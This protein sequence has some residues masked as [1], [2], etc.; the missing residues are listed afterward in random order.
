M[1]RGRRI[2]LLAHCVLNGNAKVEG[3]CG[4]RA[5]MTEVVS[6]LMASGIG[7]IQLPCP[8]MQVLGC[9]RWGHV[10]EQLDTPHFRETSRALL[11]PVVMQLQDYKRNGYDLVAVVG[12]DGSPSCGVTRTCSG[13]GWRGDFLDR[14]ETWSRVSGMVWADSPGVY[15]ETLQQMLAAASLDIPFIGLDEADYLSSL[16]QLETFLS[17]RVGQAPPDAL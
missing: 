17:H 13:P 12:V 3:I 16:R 11:T 8:E 7:M 10:K 1:K 2:V 9:A 14:D 5:A 15:I 6:R 4:Y